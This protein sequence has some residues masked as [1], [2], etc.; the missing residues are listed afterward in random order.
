MYAVTELIDSPRRLYP[1]GRLDA[2]STGLILLTNDGE[3]ANRL[4]HPR[5]AVAR[6]YRLQASLAGLGSGWEPCS[7][8]LDGE[9]VPFT[10]DTETAVLVL[11]ASASGPD[12][13][14]VVSPCA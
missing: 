11:T 7:A 8:V 14:L 10:F 13:V 9:D 4:M 3:L 6:T 5:Y 12:A 2:D 1:V